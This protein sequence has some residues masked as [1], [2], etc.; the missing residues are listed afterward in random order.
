MNTAI[1]IIFIFFAIL[2]WACNDFDKGTSSRFVCDTDE[3]SVETSIGNKTL[4]CGHTGWGENNCS[5]CH[6]IP[7]HTNRAIIDCGACHGGNGACTPPSL[8]WHPQGSCNLYNCHG[9]AHDMFTNNSDCNNCHFAA[10]GTI[11]CEM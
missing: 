7:Y 6:T 11:E 2:I 3:T 4:A 10:S 5:N 9:I 1:R 8:S